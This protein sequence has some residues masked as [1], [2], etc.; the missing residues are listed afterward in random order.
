MKN[1]LAVLT[2]CIAVCTVSARADQITVLGSAYTFAVLGASTVTNT[3]P[4]TIFGNLGLA[5]GTSITGFPPGVVTGGV[6]N[7]NNAAAITAQSNA[8]SAY[9]FLAGLS[10][11]Q[12]LTGQDLGGLTLTPGVYSFASSAQ[13]TGTL[14]L[15]F[16]GLSNVDIVLQ[17]G[18]TLT[19]ASGSSIVIIN[20]GTNDN[21]YY[22]VGSSATLGT[23]S[24]FLGD[25]LAQTSI[26][27]ETAVDIPCGS[28]LALNG[29]V[30]L[31]SDIVH[32]CSTTGSDVTPFA[33]PTP[34]PE[35]GTLV[36]VGTGLL[37]AAGAFR[38][39]LFA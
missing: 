35:P 13:L 25:I 5:P 4:T 30:T 39:R 3:G 29:A 27:L 33:P 2:L 8:F 19:T 36:M 24:T 10:P 15:D 12:N 17:V 26:T 31:D 20:Q 18:S 38:R 32:N 6:I 28:A 21:V 1:Y 37:A 22:Q 16:Q 9:N 23:G 34:I 7:N 11:T 14:T